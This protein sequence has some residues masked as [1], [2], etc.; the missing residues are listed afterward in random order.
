[1]ISSFFE[2]KGLVRQQLD[3][4]KTF[5]ENTVQEIID[6][7]PEIVVIPESQYGPEG[8][9]S[10]NL[11]EL[12]VKFEQIYLSQPMMTEADGETSTMFPRE[13]RLRNVTYSAPL[14]VDVRKTTL[15]REEGGTSSAEEQV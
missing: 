5:V 8:D 12:R 14:Y 2:E 4:F 6:E 13:A 3:S 1:M 10:E 9:S 7:T 11:Q 15:I